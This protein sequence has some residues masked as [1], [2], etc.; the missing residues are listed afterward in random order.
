ML[1]V[2]GVV[3]GIA[4]IS[5]GRLVKYVPQYI[6]IYAALTVCTGL[7]LFL[8]FWDIVPS[9]YVMFGLSIGLSL[10][11][12]IINAITPGT[13]KSVSIRPWYIIIIASG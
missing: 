11:E 10:S 8:V 12:G 9:Y 1:A 6:L 2:Y 4:A 13:F 7:S 5:A 3:G